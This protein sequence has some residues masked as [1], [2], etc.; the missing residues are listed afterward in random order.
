MSKGS[1]AISRSKPAC[2]DISPVMGEMAPCVARGHLYI[3]RPRNTRGP[4]FGQIAIWASQPLFQGIW[5][6]GIT[7]VF[8]RYCV[9]AQGGLPRSKSG[10]ARFMTISLPMHPQGPERAVTAV[11]RRDARKAQATIP[12][13]LWCCGRTGPQ[14]SHLPR[15][16]PL[17][18]VSQR[19]AEVPP[20]TVPWP[21]R[22]RRT[23]PAGAQSQN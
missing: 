21:R 3:H 16:R 23:A 13:C 22:P 14:H 17:S 6:V 5:R 10:I 2:P 15:Q 12:N 1:K 11:R 8:C 9:G 7:S 18:P 20:G 4:S 19:A